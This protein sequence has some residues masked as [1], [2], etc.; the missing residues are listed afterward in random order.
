[1]LRVRFI[2]TIKTHTLRQLQSILPTYIILYTYSYVYIAAEIASGLDIDIGTCICVCVRFWHVDVVFAGKIF[3]Y[4]TD[5]HATAA[6][7]MNSVKSC[8]TF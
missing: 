7:L 3:D 8:P 6:R 5:R 1:V 4:F 2:P